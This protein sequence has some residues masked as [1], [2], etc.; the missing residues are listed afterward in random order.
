LEAH[1][2]YF[3]VGV[4]THRDTHDA[5]VVDTNGGIR[6]QAHAAADGSGYRQL[7]RFARIHA[8]GRRLWAVEGTGSYGA[9]LTEELAAQGERV[10]EIDRPARPARRNGAKSDEL[11]AVRAAREAL[12]RDHLATPRRRGDRE[13]MRVLLTTRA[14]AVRAHNE[15]VNQLKALIVNAP[16]RLRDQLRGLGTAAQLQRCARLRTKPCQSI[17]H[18]VTIIG[19]R[20]VARRALALE[21][22]AADCETELEPLVRA[23]CPPLLELFGVGLLTAAQ[24]LVSWSHHGRLRNEA[25]FAALAGVAPIPASSG[26]VTR[27]RLSR[28][29]DRQLNRALHVVALTRLRSH[30]ETQAYAA[31]RRMEGKSAREIRRCL[32]RTLARKIF[33]IVEAHARIEQSTDLTSP[34]DT[35]TMTSREGPTRLSTPS[36][37]DLTMSLEDSASALPAQP[38]APDDVHPRDPEPE[39]DET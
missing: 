26:Q 39:L 6:A 7:L 28:G 19:L 16:Q 29:G 13:A 22:E 15:A 25:A 31:R 21:A 38:P 3:V 37:S 30:A 32:K 11:D 35:A 4:D 18:R 1:D 20:R 27:H 23:A 2:I 14:G 10:V 17:E 9:G 12:S 34:R 8:P 33:R 24:I 5:A 36:A